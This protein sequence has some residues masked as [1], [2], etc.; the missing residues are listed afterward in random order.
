MNAAPIENPPIPSVPAEVSPAL[1]WLSFATDMGYCAV[2]WNARGVCRFVLPLATKAQAESQMRLR[3]RGA[4]QIAESQIG[5][6]PRWIAALVADVQAHLAGDPRSFAAVP[7]DMTWAEGFGAQVYRECRAI[8]A[9]TVLTYGELAARVGQAGA[10]RAVGAA[11]GRNPV[12]LI[13][14]CHRVVAADGKTGGF[15]APGGAQTKLAL[16]AREGV[17]LQ[18]PKAPADQ[19][20]LF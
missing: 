12:P 14:P 9:G 20:S 18:R 13:V 10:A 2:A 17:D 16:L 5:E 11:M 4:V 6:A 19:P 15:S 8:E 1:S 3:A 7:V